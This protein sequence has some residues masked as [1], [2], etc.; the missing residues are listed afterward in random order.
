[1]QIK[2]LKKWEEKIKKEYDEFK[3]EICGKKLN[4]ATRGNGNENHDSTIH[5]DHKTGK[6]KIS[7]RHQVG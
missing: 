2:L 3:C 1:M 7:K 5:W 4:F 6:E